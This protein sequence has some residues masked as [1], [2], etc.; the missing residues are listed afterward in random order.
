MRIMATVC[1]RALPLGAVL[2]F[3][4]HFGLAAAQAQGADV[5]QACTADAMRLCNE[6]IPDEGKVKSC[7]MAKRRQLGVEC[8]TA[9]AAMRHGGHHYTH[10]RRVRYR[11]HKG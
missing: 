6:F 2:V 5:R 1:R 8:R 11:H 4:F 10:V 7:M 9:I 3:G